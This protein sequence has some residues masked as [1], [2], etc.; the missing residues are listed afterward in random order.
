MKKL[1]LFV[2]V[3]LM[4]LMLTVNS[5]YAAEQ[6][7]NAKFVKFD[8]SRDE[9][10]FEM[11]MG[12]SPEDLFSYVAKEAEIVDTSAFY[13]DD[14]ALPEKALEV[15]GEE[16]VDEYSPEQWGIYWEGT[17]IPEETGD[18]MFH[19][20]SDNG[21]LLKIDGQVV[22]DF[23]EDSWD[24]DVDSDQPIH[25]EAGKKYSIEAWYFDNFGGAYYQLMWSKDGGEKTQI[26]LSCLS[27]E[28]QPKPS[29]TP[30]P[31]PSPS[32]SQAS[33]SQAAASST[34]AASPTQST[35]E[36]TGPSPIIFIIIAVAVIAV[37]VVIFLVVSKKKNS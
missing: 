25:L 34:P 17:L 4:L 36:A 20:R 37:G 24:V 5:V 28:R 15:L 1:S 23:W 29:P 33:Q 21:F 9:F 18:Y 7:L 13:I 12:I 32:P 6:G 31:T 16:R 3:V 8:L 35:E 19:L 26:P 11:G 14:K 2:A 10:D 30:K 27:T 22:L